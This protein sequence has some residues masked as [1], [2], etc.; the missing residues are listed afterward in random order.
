[1][2][3]SFYVFW[4][5][6]VHEIISQQIA[7]CNSGC[8]EHALPICKNFYT[9]KW[10][11]VN[12]RVFDALSLWFKMTIALAPVW[13]V[14][15]IT[16]LSCGYCL[17]IWCVHAYI[18]FWM[19]QRSTIWPIP[20]SKL[21]CLSSLHCTDTFGTYLQAN[22]LQYRMQVLWLNIT[23][24]SLRRRWTGLS[25]CRTITPRSFALCSTTAGAALQGLLVTALII[26]WMLPFW[27]C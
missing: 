6:P 13:T 20:R 2:A 24:A 8:A 5:L 11:S 3:Y 19:L 23:C 26:V 12:I 21:L 16:T 4:G 10:F 17:E 7:W 1:M 18:H 22:Y 25:S 9:C 15:N 27:S 14:Q